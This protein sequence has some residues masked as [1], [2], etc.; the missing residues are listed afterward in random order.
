MAQRGD[1]LL[2]VSCRPRKIDAWEYLRDLMQRLPAAKN[3]DI[4]DLV[5][6]R[7]KPTPSSHS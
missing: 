7:W 5:P 2:I 1:I 4:P 6:S 3:H